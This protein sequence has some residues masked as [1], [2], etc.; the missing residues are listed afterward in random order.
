MR[1]TPPPKKQ[2]NFMWRNLI[3]YCSILGCGL[4]DLATANIP[5]QYLRSWEGSTFENRLKLHEY[6]GRTGSKAEVTIGIWRHHTTETAF[7]R[8]ETLKHT[9]HSVRSKERPRL[10]VEF[11]V[12]ETKICCFQLE[13]YF[14]LNVQNKSHRTVYESSLFKVSKK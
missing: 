8:H 5:L 2:N 3:E 1:V 13:I 9:R 4:C 14:D 6:R 12:P 11:T 10:S 7:L